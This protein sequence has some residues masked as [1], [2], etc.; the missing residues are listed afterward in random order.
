MTLWVL[1]RGGDTGGLAEYR[2]RGEKAV[3]SMAEY[4]TGSRLG[5]VLESSRGRT[6]P[7]LVNLRRLRRKKA[8][9]ARLKKIRPPTMPPAMAPTG[10][11][12]AAREAEEGGVVEGVSKAVEEAVEVAEFGEALDS[13]GGRVTR[14]LSNIRGVWVSSVALPM[15][16]TSKVCTPVERP[17]A[18]NR[19]SKYTYD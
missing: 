2:S 9:K 5:R 14:N 17:V 7:F 6:R 16:T 4:S 3:V 13:D 11:F 19:F 12:L 8:S 18:L 10:V 15:Y 1:R